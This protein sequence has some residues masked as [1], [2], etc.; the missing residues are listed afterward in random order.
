MNSSHTLTRLF[1]K[2]SVH[3][4]VRAEV[5]AEAYKGPMSGKRWFVR[6]KNSLIKQYS[7]TKYP[8]LYAY[9]FYKSKALDLGNNGCYIVQISVNLMSY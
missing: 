4:I 3:F 1:L 6:S 9:L 2:A 8:L 7:N 5:E